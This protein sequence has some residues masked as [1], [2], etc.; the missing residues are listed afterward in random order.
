MARHVFNLCY[1][2]ERDWSSHGWVIDD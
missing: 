1:K 2:F